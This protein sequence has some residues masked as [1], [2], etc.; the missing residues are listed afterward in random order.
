MKNI[1]LIDADSKIPNLALMKL[2]KY[3]KINGD[4]V[5]IKFLHIP[6]YPN[7]KKII[8]NIDTSD[9]DKTYCSMIFPTS[10]GYVQGNNIEFGGTGY[11]IYKK[12]PDEIENL[13]PDYSIYPENNKSYG[14]ITRGC[15]RNCS[16]CFVPKK[17]GMIHQVSTVDKIAK[18]KQV[19]FMDN[20]ILAYPDHKKIL[21]DLVDKKIRCTFNQ[22]LDLRLLDEENS[23]LIRGLNYIGEIIFAF[24]N[25]SYLPIIEDKIKLLNWRK[26]WQI[27]FYIYIHPDM[28]LSETINRIKWCEDNKCLPYIMRD[29][30]CWGSMY[31]E[32]YIDIASW[33]NQ[34]AF[35][36]KKTFEQFLNVR[37]TNKE[38]IRNSL[39]I[40][41]NN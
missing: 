3:H 25:W 20:N 10:K 15:I 38:R 2:S 1:L 36:K 26:S 6:Y 32:F 29:I 17:E 35:F 9:Y 39:T 16:F 33:C 23:K 31:N 27:K 40:W 30:S 22:G 34:P 7:R 11:D 19:I 37:H 13:E 28:G 24:D 21:Q 4:N 14:F 41:N 12:L 8:H 5:D 18:H